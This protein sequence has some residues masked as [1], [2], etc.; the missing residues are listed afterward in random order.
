[1]ISVIPAERFPRLAL[2]ATVAVATLV[3]GGCGGGGSES[4]SPP[5][6]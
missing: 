3:L 5:T 1:M 2:S 6:E 4:K